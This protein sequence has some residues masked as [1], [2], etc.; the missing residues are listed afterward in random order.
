MDTRFVEATQKTD[1]GFN[2][3]KPGLVE[4]PDA[5]PSMAGYRRTGQP[6]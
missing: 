3:G 4:L 5:E 6:A 1:G 2:W